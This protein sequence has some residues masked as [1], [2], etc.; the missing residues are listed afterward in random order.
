MPVCIYPPY[1]CLTLLIKAWLRAVAVKRNFVGAVYIA[2]AVLPSPHWHRAE[3]RKRAKARKVLHALQFQSPV[4]I[5]NAARRI[6]QH[7]G[8]R[9]PSNF[10]L[11]TWQRLICSHHNPM[12]S[13]DCDQC[14][15]PMGYQKLTPQS[16]WTCACWT[17]N[18][19]C[20]RFLLGL[21]WF[22]RGQDT[23]TCSTK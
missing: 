3:R 9:L 12:I 16:T 17:R 13:Q 20:Y 23:W 10:Q 8:S 11:Q 6:E 21:Q 19:F 2:T 18:A 4:R 15:Y 7:H 5:M 22:I 14:T 1:Y